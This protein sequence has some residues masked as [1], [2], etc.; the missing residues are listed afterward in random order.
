MPHSESVNE[1]VLGITG[2]T[3]RHSARCVTSAAIFVEARISRGTITCHY[4]EFH[5]LDLNIFPILVSTRN[6]DRLKSIWLVIN[7]T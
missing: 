1:S 2:S 5:W 6:N 4:A 7:M 3:V